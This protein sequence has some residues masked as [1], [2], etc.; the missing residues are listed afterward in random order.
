EA[1]PTEAITQTKLFEFSFTSREDAIYTMAELV[2]GDGGKPHQLPG[3]D[4]SDI[5]RVAPMTSAWLRATAPSGDA[6]FAGRVAWSGGRGFGVK[7]P[8][9]GQSAEE[10]EV[11][12][13]EA[14]AISPRPGEPGGR[15]AHDPPPGSEG[16][17]DAGGSA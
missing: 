13:G 6:D 16:H 2:V 17:R 4:W 15:A 8:E 10:G 3:E 7:E 12:T 9:R 5:D 11:D 14:D 1:C